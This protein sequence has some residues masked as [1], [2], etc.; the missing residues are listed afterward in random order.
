[1]TSVATFAVEDGIGILTIDYPPVNALG[2]AVRQGL[3]QGFHTFD[4]DPA[5]KAIV[6]IC[7]GRTFFAGADIAE[8]GK[9]LAEPDLGAVFEILDG[10]GKPVIAAIHGTALGGG[11][12]LALACHHRIA[13]PS[14]RVG[15]PEVKLGLLPGA[16]GTQR[17]PRIVGAEVALDLITSGRPVGAPEALQLGMIDALATEGRLREDAIAFARGIVAE[18]LPLRRVRDRDDK[19]LPA[20]GD[21][22]LFDAFLTRNARAFRGLKAPASI[23]EAVRAAV[24]L[25]FDQGLKR[26]ADLLDPLL[27]STESLAQR[28]A[29]FAERETSKIP[30]I[31]SAT[32]TLPVRNVGVIGA[33][34]MGGGIAMNFLNVGLPVTIVE[35]AQDALDRGVATIRRNYEA[36]ARKGRLTADQ[37]EQRMALLRPTLDMAALGEADLVIEAVY[38]SMEVKR[39][40]FARLDAIANPDAILASNTSFL[41]LDAIAAVTKRPERVIGLHFFSPANV[42]RLLEVV[43][44]EKTDP[45]VVVTAMKLAR[46]IGKVPVLARVCHGFIANRLM[47]PRGEQAEALLLEGP[48]ADAIDRVM[49]DYGFPMG[50][51]QLDDLVGLD[52]LGR[53]ATERTLRGDLV[54]LGRLGQKGGGGFY[55][56]DAQRNVTPSPIAAKAI[57]DF[58]ELKGMAD[59]GAQDADAILARLLYP[60]VNE[61][62]KILEEGIALRASDIDMAA[63]LGYGWPVQTGG[64]MLWADTIG[65]PAIVATLREYEA[66]HGEAFR[67][68]ALLERL[69]AEGGR[70]TPA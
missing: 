62:A 5:V 10:G 32:P 50:P 36:T 37:V 33:G 17:L 7:A 59:G 41:D 63:I 2:A 55:D 27:V 60:V 23:V 19:L 6:L 18:A 51:F 64:P 28:Y 9:P 8:L 58:R 57:S 42:M 47:T 49:T 52:V 43:R 61:G 48:A 15:L 25:P 4:A 26:E 46:T 44:G 56:Y 40:V 65:L 68:A 1:M 34:T 38:E 24:T 29:F 45:A 31:A 54:A 67:P 22:D 21:P 69:A 3:D 53:D 13:V 66:A 70:F 39:A 35:T 20:R 14:A 30:D 11:Y 12:E 16:G